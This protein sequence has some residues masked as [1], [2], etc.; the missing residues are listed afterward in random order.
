M[1]AGIKDTSAWHV[2][3]Q[4][5]KHVWGDDDMSDEEVFVVC[6]MFWKAGGTWK[7]IMD[8]DPE[9]VGILEECMNNVISAR[10]LEK[11]AAKVAGKV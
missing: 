6:R 7:A 3:E 11:I 4:I 8:G 5:L 9:S 10:K 2:I 1:S